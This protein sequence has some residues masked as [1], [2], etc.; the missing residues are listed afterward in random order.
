MAA[1]IIPGYRSGLRQIRKVRIGNTARAISIGSILTEDGVGPAYFMAAAAGD[2][3][4]AVALQA[5]ALADIPA[6]DG[7]LEIEADFSPE[8]VYEYSVGNGT[9]AVTMEGKQCDVYTSTTID[10]AAST[11]DAITI[12]R[13][14]VTRNTCLVRFDFNKT[15]SGVV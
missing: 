8:S 1:I 14:D 13:A 7:N 2:L 11:D 4:R 12:I 10:V 5:V 6:T 3:P 9:L 15:R